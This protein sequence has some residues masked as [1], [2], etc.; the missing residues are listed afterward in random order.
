MIP[1]PG[2][3]I[4]AIYGGII[5][6]IIS[7]T[8]FLNFI[9]CFCCAGVLLGGMLAVKFYKDNFTPDT[10]P[11]TS[12]DCL[13]VGGLAGLVG[14]ILSTI[15]WAVF[16]AI[17]GNV[18]GQFAMKMMRQ[19]SSQLPPGLFDQLQDALQQAMEEG[20][21]VVA[22][23]LELIKNFVVDIVFGGLGGL[24]GYQLFKPRMPLYYPPMPPPPPPAPPIQ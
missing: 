8:P 20:I 17:F 4:P 22:F 11:F 3:E 18:L 15:L 2:K 5:I 9:N 6:G 13:I 24:L 10:P 23:L 7:S 1:K 21:T 12:S 19:Y 16:M 14:A